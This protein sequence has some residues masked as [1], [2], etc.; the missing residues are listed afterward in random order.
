MEAM[1]A[2]VHKHSTMK[3][4]LPLIGLIDGLFAHL[5]H[6]PAFDTY[7]SSLPY[8][9]FQPPQPLNG[10]TSVTSIIY[11][12]IPPHVLLCPFRHLRKLR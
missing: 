6:G 3:C 8:M 9:F 12:I 4:T 10:H 2:R 1:F 5:L 11:R 7:P